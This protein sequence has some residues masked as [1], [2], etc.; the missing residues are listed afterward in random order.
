M[1]ACPL[2]NAIFFLGDSISFSNVAPFYDGPYNLQEEVWLVP[3]LSSFQRTY[4][5]VI[6]VSLLVE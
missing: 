4:E 2:K 6:F 3:S 5:N 1:P